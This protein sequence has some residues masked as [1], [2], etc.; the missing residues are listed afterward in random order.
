ML[1][2]HQFLGPKQQHQKQTYNAHNLKSN[3]KWKHHTIKDK[4]KI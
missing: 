2:F 1:I 4:N 3:L